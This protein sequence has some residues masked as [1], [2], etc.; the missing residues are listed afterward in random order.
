VLCIVYLSINLTQLNMSEPNACIHSQDLASTQ[1][2]DT[3]TIQ[4]EMLEALKYNQAYH[5]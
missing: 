1:H 2:P 5:D 3:F 4:I